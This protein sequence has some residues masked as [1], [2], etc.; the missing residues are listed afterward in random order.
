MYTAHNAQFLSW[1][2]MAQGRS[3][4]AFRYARVSVSKMP[5]E[6]FEMMPGFDIFLTT[7]ILAYARFGKW[8]EILAEP[9]LPK[10]FPYV[11]AIQ[12]Y[13]RGLAFVGKGQARGAGVALDSLRAIAGAIPPEATQANNS[14]QHLLTIAQRVLEAKLA[15]LEE[16][17]ESGIRL[18]EEAVGLEDQTRYDEPTDWLYPVRHILGAELLELGRAG[19]AE[20]VYRADL[21]RNPE[22][23][24][25]LFGL[26]ESLRRQNRA[27]ES[28]EVEA[29][30]RMAWTRADVRIM[31]SSY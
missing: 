21:E 5:L 2:S 22:N 1:T 30:Y 7:P 8:D 9:P 18:L 10:Y 31:A 17:P 11:S 15:L 14:A 29:R 6:M 3:A 23:G 19:E 20:K 28:A 25:A 16:K 13:A 4:D 12:H 26:T 24:W 27:V